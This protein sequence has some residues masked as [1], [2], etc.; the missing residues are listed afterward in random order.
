[1]ISFFSEALLGLM[2]SDQP[3]LDFSN[4]GIR[5]DRSF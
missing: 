3:C 5:V 4:S 1:M 2:S